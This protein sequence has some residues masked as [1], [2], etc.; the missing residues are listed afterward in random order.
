MLPAS[1]PGKPP[2]HSFSS[3]SRGS[4]DSA[5]TG[6]GIIIIERLMRLPRSLSMLLAGIA[7]GVSPARL[8]AAE[9]ADTQLI[10]PHCPDEAAAIE[11]SQQQLS[12]PLDPNQPTQAQFK[13]LSI[14]GG[15]NVQ[16]G[17][18]TVRQGER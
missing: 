11:L 10:L 2:I 15:R 4:R 16:G 5:E 17:G 13:S 9:A 18:V 3:S 7:L 8:P 1:K 14:D 6:T 12:A